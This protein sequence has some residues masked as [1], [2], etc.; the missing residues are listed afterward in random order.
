MAAASH[1]WGFFPS[2]HSNV[3]A[4]HAAAL[5]KCTCGE[6]LR[7]YATFLPM[8]PSFGAPPE[9]GLVARGSLPPSKVTAGPACKACGWPIYN[10]GLG[11]LP[12][13]D[14]RSHCFFLLEPVAA[15][16]KPGGR[17]SGLSPFYGGCHRSGHGAGR[18]LTSG[19][20]S[21]WLRGQDLN[22]RPSGYEPDELP[23]C[24][25]PPRHHTL[26]RIGPQGEPAGVGR[27]CRAP[28]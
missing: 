3:S 18:C 22:L 14:R 21:I 23:G 19:P 6:L 9:S 24:S 11:A 16:Q 15:Q 2:V 28:V 8:S 20:I 17:L 10:P 25:T 26:R 7:G 27:S 1:L 12:S 4:F 13:A 5:G